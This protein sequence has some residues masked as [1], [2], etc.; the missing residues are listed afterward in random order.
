ML[1]CPN[2][3]WHLSAYSITGMLC[4]VV[5]EKG[6]MRKPEERGELC[7]RGPQLTPHVYKNTKSTLDLYD[8]EQ[9][10]RTGPIFFHF[11]YSYK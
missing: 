6:Q 11:S 7:M 5:S 1:E 9:Y 2:L 10:V 4:K 3:K 8:A